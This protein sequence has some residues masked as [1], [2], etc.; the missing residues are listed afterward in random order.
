MRA[1][2]RACVRVCVRVCVRACSNIPYYFILRSG[3]K[4][5]DGQLGKTLRAVREGIP[6]IKAS[7]QFVVPARTLHRL[8]DNAVTSPGTLN[9]ALELL[10][11]EMTSRKPCTNTLKRWNV[12]CT[13]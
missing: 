6:L 8:R 7:K 13:A 2:V 12:A 9:L 5:G 3:G 4:Y 1:C 10:T 11:L